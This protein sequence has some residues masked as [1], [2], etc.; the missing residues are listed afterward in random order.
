MLNGM[1][2]VSFGP[3]AGIGG[4]DNQNVYSLSGLIGVISALT[5]YAGVLPRFLISIEA[6]NDITSFSEALGSSL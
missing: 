3:T 5:L 6:G 4:C 2:T 1:R